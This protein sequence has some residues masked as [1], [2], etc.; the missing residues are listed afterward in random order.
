MFKNIIFVL[1]L[2]INTV[3]SAEADSAA[4]A[5]TNASATRVRACSP[6]N[7]G[8]VIV[9]AGSGVSV[10]LSEFHLNG[11][12]YVLTA[13]HVVNSN[14][15]VLYVEDGEEHWIKCNLLSRDI[16]NDLAL[17]ESA[18]PL[19]SQFSL[20]PDEGLRFSGSK[21]GK[22]ITS[23]SGSAT[24]VFARFGI[25][26][27]MSGGPVLNAGGKLCGII[28]AGQAD[29]NGNMRGDIGIF[30]A[31]GPIRQFLSSIKKSRLP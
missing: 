5:Q 25:R 13:L 6:E 23:E 12:R 29:D 15:A 8:A 31:I 2:A 24:L 1:M 30:V 7:S 3:Q 22:P 14:T 9:Q 4:P 19:S 27:G 28:V 17:L 10:D 16:E 26:P 11:P 20:A 18:V 21:E